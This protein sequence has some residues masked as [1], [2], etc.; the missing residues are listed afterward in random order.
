[1][2]D[3]LSPP[4]WLAAYLAGVVAVT[5]IHAPWVLAALLLAAFA[6]A[7]GRRRRLLARSLRAILVFNLCVSL[8]YV[9]QALWRG[10]FRADYLLLANLRVLLLVYLGFWL[11]AAVDLLRALRRFPLL[12]LVA[13]LAIGQIRTFERII[14]DFR[15]A[16]QSRNP[17]PPRLIDQT[18]HAAAQAQ[19]LLDKSL[20]SAS[21]AA[22][23]MRSRGAFDD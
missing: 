13:T 19:T 3:R 2:A 5:F 1:M 22:L 12:Q 18:R 10:D 16:F 4:V 14:H 9:L 8:G 11:V 21:E 7:G 17:M 23:A 20:A 6:A 15:L